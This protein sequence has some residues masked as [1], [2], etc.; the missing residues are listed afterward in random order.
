MGPFLRRK[1]PLLISVSGETHVR[2]GSSSSRRRQ[3]FVVAVRMRAQRLVDT[4]CC[5]RRT[6]AESAH[7]R[8]VTGRGALG[9]SKSSRDGSALESTSG[10]RAAVQADVLV[11]AGAACAAGIVG[12][13]WA[14]RRAWFCARGAFN[15]RGR[16]ARG[17]YGGRSSGCEHVR[18]GLSTVGLA[19]Q[20]CLRRQHVS[21]A[22]VGGRS[23]RCVGRFGDSGAA[24]S[25]V[26]A[27]HFV[28]TAGARIRRRRAGHTRHRAPAAAVGWHPPL[29]CRR[30]DAVVPP[31]RL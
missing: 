22:T 3:W 19:T 29:R 10:F 7:A 24:T 26:M 16:V 18:E 17:I 21:V 11:Q 5:V 2:G 8:P 30:H 6:I 31:R 13:E 1:C 12:R 23:A 14:I 25:V 28:T 9:F 20:S 4:W 27:S 15:A